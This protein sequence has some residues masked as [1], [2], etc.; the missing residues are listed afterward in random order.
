MP[1]NQLVSIIMN[2]YNGEKYLQEALDSVIAQTY[3]N[4]EIIFWD[5]QSSDRSSEIL[6]SNDDVRLKYFSAPKHTN[7]SEARNLALKQ[8]SGEFYAFLDVDDWWDTKK[9]EKQIPFFDDAEVGLVYG[10]YW[11]V[12][13]INSIQ[14]PLF[15]N[16]LPSGYVTD[17][18]LKKYCIGLLSLII[19]KNTY[20][21]INNGFNTN[22]HIIGDF[23]LTM[24]ISKQ[25]K[26][27]CVQTP[28]AFSRFHG[29]NESF[30]KE[31]KFVHELEIWRDAMKCES[32]F[33]NQK[34]FKEFIK[35]I[36]Y[37]KASL[38][39]KTR[40]YQQV[41]KSMIYLG[42]SILQFKIILK[43]IL[44]EAIFLQLKSIVKL[45]N[46]TESDRPI[47][48]KFPQGYKNS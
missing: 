19:K 2:C 14:Y 9:L 44:P 30:L 38:Y 32:L 36:E 28:I 1:E 46:Q 20:D 43:I 48:E 40:N 25:W 45:R 37:F 42:F 23:D 24:R 17:A 3:Q 10:N 26:I 35:T 21:S 6:Q 8:A 13:E 4:W 22:Y 16:V 5:N 12:D 29:K 18:L 7:L 11:Y 41:L 31:E 47:N 15:R 33:G 39:L 27:D 34:G